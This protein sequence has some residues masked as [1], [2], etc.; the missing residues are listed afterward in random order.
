LDFIWICLSGFKFELEFKFESNRKIGIKEIGN[1]AA[2]LASGLFPLSAQEQPNH[3]Q[4]NPPASAYPRLCRCQSGP[5]CQPPHHL[6]FSFLFPFLLPLLS[7]ASATVERV[8]PCGHVR[9]RGW[10]PRVGSSITPS[11]PPTTSYIKDRRGRLP[12]TLA[13]RGIPPQFRR[14]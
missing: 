11:N 8:R 10:P 5:T 2:N 4:L 14:R 1:L 7:S 12:Q 13:A 3:A 9:R 6:F